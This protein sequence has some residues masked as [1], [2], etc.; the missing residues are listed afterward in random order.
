VIT[1]LRGDVP[2]ALDDELR[3][4]PGVELFDQQEFLDRAYGRYR[5]EMIHMLALGLAAVAFII[6]LR[7]RRWRPAAAAFL[8]ALAGAL[9]VVGVVGWVDG[10]ANLL[11][12]ASLLL[13]CAMGV[14]YGVFMVE[15]R[16]NR[17]HDA[18]TLASCLLAAV[19]TML[20]FGVLAM[21]DN[22]ALA[23]VGRAVAV[24]VIC[25]LVTTPVT[26]TL[27]LSARAGDR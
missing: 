5:V 16:S 12:A 24:G 17:E 14:D 11:H 20:S 25:A 26:A 1:W 3:A 9:G 4:I 7:Y 22:P 23:S 13:V 2:A 8:P 10:S 19:T 6:L 21:S 15:S 18:V 27:R